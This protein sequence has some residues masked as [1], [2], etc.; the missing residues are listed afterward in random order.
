MSKN[1]V[2]L[3]DSLPKVQSNK[4][5]LLLDFNPTK[6]DVAIKETGSWLKWAGMVDSN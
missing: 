3:F 6:F 1:R 5:S 4:A 2:E